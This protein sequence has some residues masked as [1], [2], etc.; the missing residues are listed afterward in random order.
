[1]TKLPKVFIKEVWELFINELDDLEEYKIFNIFELNDPP[2]IISQIYISE[3]SEKDLNHRDIKRRRNQTKK[4]WVE[5]AVERFHKNTNKNKELSKEYKFLSDY[6][7]QLG[8]E[9][10]KNSFAEESPDA[11]IKNKIRNLDEWAENSDSLL[12]NY[13]YF[14][15][16]TK[17]QTKNA[18]VSD[19]ATFISDVFENKYNSNFKSLFVERPMVYVSHPIFNA[20]NERMDTK[21]YKNTIEDDFSTYYY[22]DYEPTD[23]YKVRTLITKDYAEKH[24]ALFLDELDNKIFD[25]IMTHRGPSFASHRKIH[26]N[27]GDI[28]RSIYKSNGINNYKRIDERLKK[29]L[30]FKFNVHENNEFIGFGILDYVSIDYENNWSVEATVGEVIHREFLNNYTVRLYK[31]EIDGLNHQLSKRLTFILQKER[32]EQDPKISD[33]EDFSMMYD[34]NFFAHK[35]KLP[36]RHNKESLKKLDASLDEIISLNIGIQDFKRTNNIYTIHFKKLDKH[37]QKDLV[38][39]NGFVDNLIES[40]LLEN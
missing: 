10:F 4:R 20:S 34:Y 17:R 40:S 27:V 26:F 13:L 25:Q 30:N 23:Y 9:N 19:L 18:I 24:S 39:T 36:V 37:E 6:Y 33:E 35:L 2:S 7:T 28:V 31:D 3:I 11:L 12:T 14:R 22:D 8:K 16:K 5:S 38:S 32:L 29:M 1:M 21:S 15:D